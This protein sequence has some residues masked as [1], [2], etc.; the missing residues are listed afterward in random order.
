MIRKYKVK[1]ILENGDRFE[2]LLDSEN[3]SNALVSAF[4]E[5]E[6]EIY[7]YVVKYLYICIKQ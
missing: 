5:L 3:P 2:T 1:I 7:S 6:R 4:L